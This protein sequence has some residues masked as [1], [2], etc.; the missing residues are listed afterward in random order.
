ML[1]L[2]N[3]GKAHFLTSHYISSH[4]VG[5]LID[6]YPGTNAV[7]LHLYPAWLRSFK[8][9]GQALVELVCMCVC[10]CVGVIA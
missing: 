7:G 4:V 10:V 9:S 6:Y 8:Y 3:S 1:I 2:Y 5:I